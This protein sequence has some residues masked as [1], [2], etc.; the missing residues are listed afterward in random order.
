MKTL[1]LGLAMSALTTGPS[2]AQTIKAAAPPPLIPFSG[3]LTAPSGDPF[4]GLVS[5]I[6]SL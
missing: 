2:Q 1:L 6:F 5:A 4:V 3:A